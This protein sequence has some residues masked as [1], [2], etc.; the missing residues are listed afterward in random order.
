MR[1]SHF[2]EWFV[3]FCAYT[4]TT[5]GGV[6]LAASVWWMVQGGECDWRRLGLNIC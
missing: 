1:T 6:N 4:P 3:F 5:S 2:G